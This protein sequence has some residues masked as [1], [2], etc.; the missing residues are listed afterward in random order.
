MGVVLLIVIVL[1]TVIA[2]ST[3]NSR[4]R[5]R[6]LAG[7][8]AA[9]QGRHRRAEPYTGRPAP[10]NRPPM[11]PPYA[12]SVPVRWRGPTA[13]APG[14]EDPAVLA[15]AWAPAGQTVCVGGFTIPGGLIYVAGRS[16]DAKRW[17]EPSLIDHSLPV[18]VGTT[19]DAGTPM[20]YKSYYSNITP[21]CRAAY[22]HW[23]ANGRCAPD[24]DINY[25]FLYFFGLE[26]RVLVDA[27]HSPAVQGEREVLA[28]EIRRLMTIYGNNGGFAHYA[29][30]LLAVATPTGGQRRY[31]STPP[32]R[33]DG[34]VLPFDLRLGIGQ[35]I[36][37]GKPIPPDWAL[38]WVRLHPDAWLRTPATRCVAEFDEAFTYRYRNQYGDGL[39]IR[40]DGTKLSHLYYPANPA[41]DWQP[42]RIRSDIPDVA[43][44]TEPFAKLREL[45]RD[46]CTDLDEYSRYLGRHPE[47]VGTAAA[48]AL[49]P[50]RLHR[51]PDPASQALLSW[52]DA[53]LGSSNLVEVAGAEL[54]ARWPNPVAHRL[55]R[56]DAVLL[57]RLLERYGVGLEPDVRFGGPALSSQM[58]AVLFRLAAG[59]VSMPTGQYTA[60]V[61][62][63][64]LAAAVAAADGTVA[65]SERA[66]LETQITAA[67]GLSG[68]EHRRLRA[69]L[70]HVLRHPPTPNALRKQTAVFT[71]PQ[72][73][74]T[75]ELLIAVAAAD[76]VIT[77]AEVG[78]LT[79]LFPS[80]GLDLAEVYRS[81]S[82][83]DTADTLTQLR[84]VGS[85]AR[86]YAIPQPQADQ[87][88]PAVIL[89]PQ[90]VAARLADSAR[91]AA[92]LA[93]IFTDEKDPHADPATSMPTADT[94]VEA[95]HR[96]HEK[97]QLNEAASGTTPVPTA[98]TSTQDDVGTQPVRSQTDQEN[99]AVVLDPDLI[100]ARLA[101][102][103]RAASYLA[104][105]F[106]D[107]D[108]ITPVAAAPHPDSGLAHIAGL[109]AVHSWLLR[110]LAERPLWARREFDT[111]T[112]ELGL[113][114]DGA[115][116]TLNEAAVDITGEPV[117]EGADPVQLNRDA[118]EEM[119][120]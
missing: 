18:G 97:V 72:R 26:R 14:G 99:P 86:D 36:A 67:F 109:D 8:P 94:A 45:A 118:V 4:L 96:L 89:N 76:G 48:L 19:D 24:A 73:R 83:L 112:A 53:S 70:A 58:H 60:A 59:T 117:C 34:W 17:P 79:R 107:E 81:I 52:V 28:A 16:T 3:Q 92:Y 41:L 5:R 33:R 119:L 90:V 63:T 100:A 105:I 62:A 103:A 7:R 111:I 69:H 66:Q 120:R 56:S 84:T 20:G 114:S 15:A 64:P 39:H 29:D 22:L 25:V 85:R 115:L 50:P 74:A 51:T 80:L 46:V 75:G 13:T 106:T 11:P 23:L 2:V 38:A 88:T 68:D 113:L 87:E 104:Q 49:L 31:L 65:D 21:A 61:A 10:S 78:A 82:A 98:D 1:G 91:A 44:L 27:R 6:R 101:D 102:S 54:I 93:Q 55:T 57:A 42:V 77:Q 116:D 40:F 47:G 32:T 37:D 43:A 95:P 108:T 35:L 30:G 110:R 71:E 9:P 12:R